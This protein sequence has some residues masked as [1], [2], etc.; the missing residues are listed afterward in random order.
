MSRKKTI[1]I[2]HEDDT[3]ELKSDE[4]TIFE[5]FFN[6]AGDGWQISIYRE[7]PLELKG[8]LEEIPFEDNVVNLEYLAKNWGGKRLRIMLRKPNGEW[9]GRQYLDLRSYPPLF[10]GRPL[11]WEGSYQINGQEQNRNREYS[12]DSNILSAAKILKELQPPQ[13]QMPIYPNNQNQNEALFRILELMITQ[14]MSNLN[15]M[16]NSRQENNQNSVQNLSEMMGFLGQARDFWK[17]DEPNDGDHLGSIMKIAEAVLTRPP[18]KSTGQLLPPMPIV[19]RQNTEITK[20]NIN[21]VNSFDKNIKRDDDTEMTL[22]SLTQMLQNMNGEEAVGLFLMKL[23]DLTPSERAKAES[24][25]FEALGI[26]IENS[27]T[28]TKETIQNRQDSESEFLGSDERHD[29]NNRNR[30]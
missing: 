12:N 13:Q 20:N 4:T 15:N 9:G 18:Q 10:R 26:E 14:Q 30:H 17:R 8:F 25:L 23:R 21:N 11:N 3:D 1:E 16:Q 7:E 27:N 28:D 6:Q 19:P 2:T 5:N 29:P 24:M 22:D